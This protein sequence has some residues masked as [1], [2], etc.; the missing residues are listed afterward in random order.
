MPPLTAK[1][2]KRLEAKTECKTPGCGGLGHI[3]GH[4][5]PTHSCLNDCPYSPRNIRSAESAI[6]DR[7]QTSSARTVP[8]SLGSGV[9]KRKRPKYLAESEGT[10]E[11][12]EQVSAKISLTPNQPTNSSLHC[13]NNSLASVT[14]R[15]VNVPNSIRREVFRPTHLNGDDED[16]SSSC[17]ASGGPSPEKRRKTPINW[18]RN[19]QPLKNK[20]QQTR[21]HGLGSSGNG[22]GTMDRRRV[23][24]WTPRQV[25]DFVASI[26]T[27]QSAGS[28]LIEEEVDGESFLMLTQTDLIQHLGFRLGPA[29]KL[30]NAILLIKSQGGDSN[31]F[32]HTPYRN[33]RRERTT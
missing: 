11:P 10:D 7:L 29:V 31:I 14:K 28:R 32:N 4:L 18:A 21:V 27:T 9:R 26:L 33:H 3:K 17:S 8:P 19:V 23:E 5:H 16:F 30:A 12:D 1:E 22:R 13:E 25:A 15:Q 2:I 6:P 24:T 20:L